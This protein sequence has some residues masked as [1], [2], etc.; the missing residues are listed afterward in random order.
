[1]LTLTSDVTVARR[2][3]GPGGRLARRLPIALLVALLGACSS[4]PPAP[5]QNQSPIASFSASPLQGVAPLGVTFD[6]SGSLDADGSIVAYAWQF[7]DG[8]TAS[9]V[10]AQHT[11]AEP[12]AYTARL[13]VTDD[14][15]A[16]GSAQRTITVTDSAGI[17]PPTAAFTA[18]PDGGTAPLTVTFD[19]SAS[20][21]PSG[22]LAYAWDFGDGGAGTGSI[23]T[24]TYLA[25]GTYVA[26]LTVTDGGG[27]ASATATITVT[28]GN[29]G[30]GGE[31]QTMETS[32]VTTEAVFGEP[33]R[34]IA[35]SID[36][37]LEA[38]RRNGGVGTLTGTLTET[39]PEVFTYAATPNDRLRLQLLNDRVV[40]ITFAS[41]PQGDFA[42]DGLRFVRSPHVIDVR[43][44]SNAAAGSLDVTVASSPGANAGTQVGRFAGSFVDGAGHAW[45][46]SVDYESF[47]RTEVGSGYNELESILSM[48]GTLQSTSRGIAIDLER[49][50]RYKLVNTVEQVDDRMDH[51]IAWG[52]DTY[53]LSGRVFVSFRDSKPVDRDQWVIAGMLTRNGAV[54][55]QY[56][57]SEDVAGLTV[58]LQVGAE[59]FRLSF[60]SYL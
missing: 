9:G 52:G 45:T 59:S 28:G 13:T 60:F 11:Y 25:A 35:A 41:A 27:S 15:G 29:G 39:A 43:V 56:E 49:R 26:R 18:T 16:T 31:T 20:S 51:T 21:G 57:A 8:R 5:G 47:R 4:A 54:I 30:S 36:A 14:A 2:Y 6:A 34:L 37:A 44:T 23:A 3:G 7:G 50:N 58:R 38:T 12:G 53:R 24:H 17:V 48:K 19:A 33:H 40:E 10:A 42:G 55:G 1:M 32:F 46:A 22:A